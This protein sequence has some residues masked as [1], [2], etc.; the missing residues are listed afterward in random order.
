MK[1]LSRR[2]K[3]IWSVVP[4]LAAFFC[5]TIPELAQAGGI[6]NFATPVEQVMNT[7]T[8]PVGKSVAVIGMALCGYYFITNKEDISGGAKALLGIVFGICFIAFA[9]PIVNSLFSFEGALI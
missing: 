4:F 5:L 1:L 8:G 2:P 9:A 3:I 7:V 6:A